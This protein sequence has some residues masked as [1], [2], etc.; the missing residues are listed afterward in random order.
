[1]ENKKHYFSMQKI[2]SYSEFINEST[3]LNA[4]LLNDI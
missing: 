2:K 3:N 1:M 4:D